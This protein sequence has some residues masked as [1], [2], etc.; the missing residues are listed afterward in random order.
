MEF[1]LA[2]IVGRAQVA[3][4]C[5]ANMA[6][7]FLVA[8]T[9]LISIGNAHPFPVPALLIAW[10]HSAR[11]LEAL[12]DR[13]PALLCFAKTATKLIG[14]PRMLRPMMPAVRFE[15]RLP[16][17]G[18]PLDEVVFVAYHDARLLVSND[19]RS[20]SISSNLNA[21]KDASPDQVKSRQ[22]LEQH[23]RSR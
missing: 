12:A 5:C 1:G 16:V 19:R 11:R 17:F 21:T 13:A 14:Q 9:R 18:D 3:V 7:T 6:G 2:V 10:Y 4:H 8:A 20:P 15:M 22:S 23:N